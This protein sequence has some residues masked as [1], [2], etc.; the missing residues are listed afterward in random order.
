VKRSDFKLPHDK[1]LALVMYDFH[2]YQ[3]RKNPEAAIAAF[4]QAT[5]GRDDAV[6]VVKTINAHHHPDAATELRAHLADMPGTVVI[7]EF[8]T[9]QQVWD[10][11]SL[12]DMLVS[13]HR[14]EGFGLAPAEMMSLGKPVVATGWSANMD[15][16]TAENSMPVRY[17]L[18]PLKHDIGPYRAGP[19]WA[20][21]DVE[22]AASCIRR[23]LDDPALRER[24][25]RQAAVDIARQLSPQAVGERV[26]A[27]LQAVAFW[28][29]DLRVQLQH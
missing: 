9:R 17:A 16:M 27:R 28:R 18:E 29:P 15:F 19:V 7:D 4:R 2:S 10:L 20:E 11:Q 23:L 5:V 8:L 3:Y 25:G 24:M 13:L 14:A 12:C 21:A 6:L 22:H 26:R 1:L